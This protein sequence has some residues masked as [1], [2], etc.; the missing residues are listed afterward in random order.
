M[1]SCR[2]LLAVVTIPWCSLLVGCGSSSCAISGDVL[3]DGQPL[4]DGRIALRPASEASGVR[5]VQAVVTDGAYSFT[6]NQG[7]APGTYS[8][9][10][11]GRR[12]TGDALPPEEGSGEVIERYEQYLPA[13]YNTNTELTANI[14]GD[15]SDLNF[16]L[17]LSQGGRR[18]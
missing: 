9:V 13:R 10:I 14:V 18:R 2:L 15:A 7:I 5:T 3:V 1:R 16:E 4:P 12:K 6:K 17:Q 11:T 8:V